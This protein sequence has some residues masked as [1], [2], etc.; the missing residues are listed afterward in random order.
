MH[1]KI[2]YHVSFIIIFFI[3]CSL[4]LSTPHAEM[5]PL[6]EGWPESMEASLKRRYQDHHLI[7]IPSRYPWH[8]PAYMQFAEVNA[9]PAA[10]IQINL[11]Y[12]WYHLYGAAPINL[13][14][15]VGQ[16]FVGRPP[17]KAPQAV[18]FGQDF[19]SYGPEETT[20]DYGE[21]LVNVLNDYFWD[22][23]WD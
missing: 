19:I 22:F 8:I 14:F 16:F 15:A 1:N 20:G 2:K 7:L 6:F 3:V 18:W 9:F 13:M 21:M 5:I 17:T 4:D 11:L 23:W 10:E 12:Q